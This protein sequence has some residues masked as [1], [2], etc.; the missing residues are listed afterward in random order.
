MKKLFLDI[1]TLPAD[2]LVWEKVRV[3]ISDRSSYGKKSYSEDE[4]YRRTALDG[5]FGRLLC[6]GYA[7]EPP[8]GSKSQIIIGDEVKILKKFW[9]VAKDVDVFIGHNIMDFDLRFIYKRSVVNNVKP[10]KF[11]SFARYRN[12]PIFDTLYE[13]DKWVVRNTEHTSLDKLAKAL[14][15]PSSK[16]ELDGSKVYDYYQNGKLKEIYDYCKADVEVTRQVYKRM[17]FEP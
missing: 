13:W 11:L 15:I 8:A 4:L 6:I 1:E 10:T 7:K 5:N 2:R 16:G 3:G 9:D 12:N 14:D 17:T